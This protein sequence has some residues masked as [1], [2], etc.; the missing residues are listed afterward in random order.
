MKNNM[1]KVILLSLCMTLALGLVYG[2]TKKEKDIAAIKSMTGCYEVKFNFAET[3]DYVEDPE[4]KPSPIKQTGGLEWV[5]LVE[6]DQNNIVLQHLLVVGPED[7]Q[8]VIKHWRQDWSY[9]NRDL[10]LYDGD[11]HWVYEAKSKD[12]VAGQWTQKVFQVDDS[13]RYEGSASWVHVDGKSYWENTTPAP[14]PRREYT[15]RSDYNLTMRTNRHEITEDGWIHDQD[16]QKI[17]RENGQDQIIA[18]EK[19]LNTYT[20]VAD[21]RCQAAQEW[22]A[23]NADMWNNVRDNWASVFAK[24]QSITLKPKVNNKRL[25]EHLFAMD[26]N[27]AKRKEIKQIITDFVKTDTKD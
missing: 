18:E 8:H 17:L 19:G 6:A 10:F 9:E 14:L 27:T 11:N 22:W 21:E 7:D 16:N 13:P 25:Y 3:F 4:Y 20:K 1:R 26:A 24:K 12:E 5:Q 15:I 2:Q 23:A